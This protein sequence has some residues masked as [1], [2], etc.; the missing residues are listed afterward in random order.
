MSILHKVSA[1]QDLYFEQYFKFADSG[2]FCGLYMNLFDFSTK[3]AQNL[4]DYRSFNQNHARQH[5]WLNIHLT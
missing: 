5:L 1:L 2:Q 3:P 4:P